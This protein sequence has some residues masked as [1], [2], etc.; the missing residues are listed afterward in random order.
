M[1]KGYEIMMDINIQ[2]IFT[3]QAYFH[4]RTLEHII[5]SAMCNNSTRENMPLIKHISRKWTQ[6]VDDV[7][8]KVVV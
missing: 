5:H 7:R 3:P 1:T 4:N 6:D 2:D 8:Y